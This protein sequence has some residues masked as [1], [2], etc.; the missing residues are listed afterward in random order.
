MWVFKILM[1]WYFQFLDIGN[2]SECK[3]KLD[4]KKIPRKMHVAYVIWNFRLTSNIVFMAFQSEY[5]RQKF[6]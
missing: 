1:N 4:K 6:R 3:E 5:P 2:F